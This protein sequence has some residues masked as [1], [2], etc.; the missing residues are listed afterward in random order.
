MQSPVRFAPAR[1]LAL[2]AG[3]L[4]AACGFAACGNVVALDAGAP[5]DGAIDDPSGASLSACSPT[6]LDA[7]KYVS[8]LHYDVGVAD[9]ELTDPARGN[10]SIPVRAHY[11]MPLATGELRA[12]VVWNHGGFPSA[13]AR[14]RSEEWGTALAAAGY[15]VIHPSRVL[16]ADAAP[17]QTVCDR[18]GF[19]A[20]ADCQ[21]FIS[22]RV[23][24]P[25]TGAFILDSLSAIETMIPQ[26]TGH[27]DA[28]RVAVA[29]HSAGSPVPM[30]F[31]GATRQF[32]GPLR[33]SPDA[34]PLAFLATGPHGPDYADFDDGFHEDSFHTID[35]RPFL[36][37][38]GRGD[39]T[40]DEGATQ[41]EPSEA[42]AAAWLTSTRGNKLLSWDNDEIAVHET[43][44]IHKCDQSATQRTHCDAFAMLGTAFLDA[45]V[46]QRTAAVTYLASSAYDTLN[47]GVI[48]LH[49]R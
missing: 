37:I 8:D 14:T 28:A 45:F 25:Q 6:N 17:F 5:D 49:R 47:A 32:A 12:V 46:R 33:Q 34:R 1:A 35:T 42:R 36:W 19:P 4:G 11:P 38:T 27:V 44:D 43:M 26:I 48:E 3:L 16:I 2:R 23:F 40:G 30:V 24:G 13:N 18:E 41:H 10:L 21:L 15:I 20:P 9:I 22:Q 39:E 29:G 31:A 7:C